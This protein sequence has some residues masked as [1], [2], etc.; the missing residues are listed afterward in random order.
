[1]EHAKITLIIAHVAI[2]KLI[3][4]AITGDLTNIPIGT[5]PRLVAMAANLMEID[6]I[7]ID[8]VFVH[9]EVTMGLSLAQTKLACAHLMINNT[10]STN[11]AA[12]RNNPIRK[13]IVQEMVGM[14][15]VLIHDH[16]IK[17]ENNTEER[18]GGN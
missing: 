5:P 17:G 10:T 14:L 18:N 6:K 9:L 8:P 11:A 1:M 3:Q 7:T 12:T 13:T 4:P 16:N 15:S 2:V